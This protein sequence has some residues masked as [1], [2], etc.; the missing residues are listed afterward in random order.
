L[1][2]LRVGVIGLGSV[3]QNRHLREYAA[4]PDVAVVAVADP[5]QTKA[6]AVAARFA[7]CRPYADWRAML[8]EVPL[9]AVSICAPNHVHAP[10]AIAALERGIHVLCE[11]P[12]ATTLAEARAMLAAAAGSGAHLMMAHNQRFDA[13]HRT[14][15]DIIGSGRLGRVLAFRSFFGTPGPDR[16]LPE[17]LGSWFF[18]REHAFAGALADLAAHKAD[19]IPWLVGEPVTQVTCLLA[20]GNKGEAT[21]DDNAAL[22]LRL[23]G[24]AVGTIQASWTHAP[25]VENATVLYCERGKVRILD[26]PACELVVEG[27]GGREEH[28]VGLPSSP[29]NP[30]PS[31]VIDHFVDCVRTGRTPDV[32]GADGYAALRVLIGA[33]EA[34][35]TGR[36]VTL[37]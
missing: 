21:V 24:G 9:D 15:R 36:T 34:A 11:K 37:A 20:G 30:I 4:R 29:R 14:A 23:A 6:A 17:G 35:E 26:D 1:T 32:T 16:W 10:A 31:G 8:A 27:E 2:V 3:A 5:D 22:V 33:L 12:M 18:R 7:G 25:G 19:L 13:V 28:R